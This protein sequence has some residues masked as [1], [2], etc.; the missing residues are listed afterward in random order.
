MAVL[1]PHDP[2]QFGEERIYLTQFTTKNSDFRTTL[3]AEI[4]G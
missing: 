2:K 4:R 3:R 1:K